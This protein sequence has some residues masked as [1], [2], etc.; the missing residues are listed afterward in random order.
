MSTWGP[1]DTQKVT[2]WSPTGTLL[3]EYDLAGTPTSG[4]SG[5]AVDSAGDLFVQQQAGGVY[6]FPVNGSGEIEPSNNTPVYVTP[7][8]SATGVAYDP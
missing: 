3:H 6:E 5:I 8:S 2:V 1:T 7:G 4:P